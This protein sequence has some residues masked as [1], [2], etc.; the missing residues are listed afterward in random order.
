MSQIPDEIRDR[1]IAVAND[2]FNE[3]GRVSIPTVGAVRRAAKA[4]MNTTSVVMREWR[5]AQTAQSGPAVAVPDTIAHAH[6]NALSALW[7]Q[8]VD[9]AN[10]SQQGAQAAWDIER[11]E[12]EAMRVE[13][14]EDFE[15]QAI[16][17]DQVRGELVKAKGEL[18]Q[19]V[20]QA[21]RAKAQA[22]EI[23][24]R[25]SDLRAELDRAHQESSRQAEQLAKLQA[26][27]DSSREEAAHL[28]GR[29]E[30]MESVAAK[31]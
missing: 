4:D 16:E 31:K 24:H 6:A 28:R 21:E 22:V 12:L 20:M 25:A 3:G 10:E 17:L 11:A 27:R 2:L 9:L 26:E 8:A 7:Q 30:A 5:H 18:S 29:L 13:V 15:E 14:A 23:E 1:I 19:A